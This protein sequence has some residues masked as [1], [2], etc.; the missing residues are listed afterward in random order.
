M[1]HRIG[2][3]PVICNGT[4]HRLRKA[5][6]FV[7]LG[8]CPATMIISGYVGPWNA[9]SA[10]E[11]SRLRQ[12]GRTWRAAERA[13]KCIFRGF[14]VLLVADTMSN[15]ERLFRRQMLDIARASHG[16]KESDIPRHMIEVSGMW[17][18]A[19][20]L[21]GKHSQRWRIIFDH[22]ANITD[23]VRQMIAADPALVDWADAPASDARLWWRPSI[24]KHSEAISRK[25][26]RCRAERV[27]SS[28]SAGDVQP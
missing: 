14:H 1:R 4:T 21:A 9:R 15:A 2:D 12:S 17:F 16:L 25:C 6:S 27:F 10:F 26:W 23:Q 11:Q 5:D 22:T 20:R 18:L 7:L 28:P 3:G 8:I 13:L 19:E 24:T